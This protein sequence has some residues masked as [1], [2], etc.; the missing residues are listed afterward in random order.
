MVEIDI[1]GF[2]F[3]C[4]RSCVYFKQPT[5]KICSSCS[6]FGKCSKIGVSYSKVLSVLD[7]LCWRQ[8]YVEDPAVFKR[9]SWEFNHSGA[10]FARSF[11]V[12][13]IFSFE[14][15]VDLHQFNRNYTTKVVSKVKLRRPSNAWKGLTRLCN[16]DWT[17]NVMVTRFRWHKHGLLFYN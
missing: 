4:F 11:K 12:S 8:S 9:I 7:P 10:K 13:Y 6:S 17:S 3:G 1:G 15:K 14:P 16:S 5:H 2:V